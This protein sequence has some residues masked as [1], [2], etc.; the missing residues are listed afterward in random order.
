MPIVTKAVNAKTQPTLDARAP[1]AILGA[2][3]SDELGSMGAKMAYARNEEI[4]G[5]GE[6]AEY[7]Y[8]VVSGS[9]RCSRILADGRRQISAFYLPGD[10]FGLEI[11]DEHS[12]SCESMGATSVVVF[13]RSAIIERAKRDLNVARKLWEIT[14]ADLARAQTHALQL[15]RSAEE[16]VSSFLLAM[17]SRSSNTVE[18][19]LPMTRQDIADHLGLTIETVSRSMTHFR[20][21]GLIALPCSRRVVLLKRSGL[22]RL[23]G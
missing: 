15:I 10:F 6:P 13:K 17:A 9:V 21:I 20:D 14:T 5:E 22:E 16:R 3:L 1:A 19:E 12:S 2:T 4:F 18:F 7:L 11:G 23:N 8:Q